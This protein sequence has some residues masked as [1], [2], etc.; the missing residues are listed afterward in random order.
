MSINHKNTKPKPASSKPMDANGFDQW[1]ANYNADVQASDADKRYPFAAYNKILDRLVELVQPALGKAILDVG[2]GTGKLSRRLADLGCRITGLDFS[3][4]MLAEARKLLPTAILIQWDFSRG[5][6]P[7]IEEHRYDTIL[8]NYAIHH[9]CD[10]EQQELIAQ[11][12]MH[13]KSEGCLLIA[14][15]MTETAQ[16]MD[17]AKKA[18]ADLWDE[19]ENYL[20]AEKVRQWF[21]ESLFE[22][23]RFSYCSGI[24]S[25]KKAGRK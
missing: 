9:L 11:I 3:D 14:D 22:F 20:L 6:P 4:S 10:H 17:Y 7:G 21:P 18:D 15:V 12:L 2:I 25:V 24:L 19:E 23:E 13:L 8:C 1:S 5:L 16:E